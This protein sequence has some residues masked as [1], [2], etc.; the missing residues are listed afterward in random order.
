MQN[1]YTTQTR[2]HRSLAAGEKILWDL[3]AGFLWERGGGRQPRNQLFK[4]VSV[5]LTDDLIQHVRAPDIRRGG[6]VSVKVSLLT[7]AVASAAYASA[8]PGAIHLHGDWR[9]KGAHSRSHGQSGGSCRGHGE[10]SA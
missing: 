1:D 7:A 2:A 5:E 6:A 9:G 3:R 4:E 10:H 8:G